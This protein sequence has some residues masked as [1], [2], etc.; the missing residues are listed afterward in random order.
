M[1]KSTQFGNSYRAAEARAAY[2]CAMKTIIAV[3]HARQPALAAASL[4]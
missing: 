2:D 4:P 1:Q 3:P